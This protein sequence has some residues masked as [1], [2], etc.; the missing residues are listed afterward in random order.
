MNYNKGLGQNL[1]DENTG[2]TR[3]YSSVDKLF[4]DIKFMLLTP[5]GSVYGYPEYGSNLSTLLYKNGTKATA[6]LVGTAVYDVLNMFDG[7]TVINVNTELSADKK[8]IH[9]YYDIIYNAQR[10][11]NTLSIS[12]G[13]II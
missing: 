8:V 3:I 13:G 2:A 9:V 4:E 1:I 5:K 10:I 7:V 12:N 11:N 6:D